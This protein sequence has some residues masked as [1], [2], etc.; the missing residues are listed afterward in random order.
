MG[1]HEKAEKEEALEVEEQKNSVFY[2]RLTHEQG[3]AVRGETDRLGISNSDF[4]KMLVSQYFD[5]IRFERKV[6]A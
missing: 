5:S 2:I 6:S 1:E 4:F 3:K